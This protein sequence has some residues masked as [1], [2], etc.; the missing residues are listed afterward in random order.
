MVLNGICILTDQDICLRFPRCPILSNEDDFRTL[1]G[2][3]STTKLRKRTSLSLS[4]KAEGTV[5]FSIMVLY[6]L[7]QV[8][9]NLPPLK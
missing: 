5:Q 2:L 8:Y 3:N 7:I 6:L 9:F 1:K 4:N